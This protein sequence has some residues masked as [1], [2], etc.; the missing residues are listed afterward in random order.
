MLRI[1]DVMTRNV[2][3]ATPDMPLTDALALLTENHVSGAPVVDGGKVAGVFSA[4]DLLAFF[5][6]LQSPPRGLAFRDRR[7]R[8][9]PLEDVT[10]ADV[11]TRQVESLPPDCSVEEA[12]LL[13][14]RKQIHR[15]MVMMGDVLLGI[16]STADVAK[17]VA[18]QRIRNRTFVFA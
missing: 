8:A 18:E 11:M 1:R 15:V 6:D 12:A 3:T 14:G 9:A 10:V 13:M 17:A 2:L 4:T 16:V 7:A 5:A